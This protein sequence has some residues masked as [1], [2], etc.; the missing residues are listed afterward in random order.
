[1]ATPKRTK[2][3][4]TL[5]FNS[6]LADLTAGISSVTAVPFQIMVAAGLL[7][8]LKGVPDATARKAVKTANLLNRGEISFAEAI[9]SMEAQ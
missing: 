2:Q 9:A 3:Q 6:E 1:M 8:F 4:K 7:L 5:L